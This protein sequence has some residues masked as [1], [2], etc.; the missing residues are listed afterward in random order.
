[1]EFIDGDMDYSGNRLTG[2]P[3]HRLQTG[4]RISYGK[5]FYWSNTYQYVGTIP[6]TDSNSVASESF[7]LL[8]SRLGYTYRFSERF[9]AGLDLGANNIFDVRYAQSVLINAV[10][11]G[12][13]EP[14]YY[15]PGN[16]RNFYGG[17]QLHYIF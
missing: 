6:L 16:D 11:F 14:R 15:Y 13:A 9:H 1:V 7:G 17:L 8:N 12:G 3:R 2:V 5:S 4:M 10:G